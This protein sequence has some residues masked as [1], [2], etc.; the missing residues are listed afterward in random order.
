LSY[1]KNEFQVLWYQQSRRTSYSI[2]VTIWDS[3]TEQMKQTP[4]TLPLQEGGRLPMVSP[5][6]AVDSVEAQEPEDT[7][8]SSNSHL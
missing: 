7:Q 2:C 5:F 4:M 3:T 8:R 1:E 6:L